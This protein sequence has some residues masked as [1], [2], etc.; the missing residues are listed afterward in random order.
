MTARRST[1]AW[2]RSR[3]SS[4]GR[5]ADSRRRGP[6]SRNRPS[7]HRAKFGSLRLLAGGRRFRRQSVR[8]PRD[9]RSLRGRA[10]GDDVGQVIVRYGGLIFD[11]DIWSKLAIHGSGASEPGD[12]FFGSSARVRRLRRQRQRRPRDRR[13]RREGR[14]GRRRVRRRV[15]R[16]RTAGREAA[17]R[18]IALMQNDGVVPGINEEGDQ[19]GAAV[20]AGDFDADGIDDLAIGAPFE[21]EG[22]LFDV[23][24]EVVLYGSRCSATA[25]TTAI[26]GLVGRGAVSLRPRGTSRS[27]HANPRPQAIATTVS[28]ATA[29]RSFAEA[30]QSRPSSARSDSPASARSAFRTRELRAAASREQRRLRLLVRDRR[31][32]RRRGGRPRDRGRRRR[33]RLQGFE[34]LLLGDQF[35]PG[36]CR[37]RSWSTPSRSPTA[38]P[39]ARRRPTSSVT[40]SPRAISTPTASTSRSA[41]RTKTASGRRFLSMWARWTFSTAR[42]PVCRTSGRNI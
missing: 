4:E 17:R 35:A 34:R 30:R 16:D 28:T 6:S 25:S 23:G 5:T 38:N 41:F 3:S 12:R 37:R 19:F 26:P 15:R 36:F 11:F 31:L 7:A 14:R 22:A 2:E 33:C 21:D 18:Q 40:R 20:A 9:R 1:R 24:A 8:R 39:A 27:S 32:R 42:S 10:R 29:C 13:A